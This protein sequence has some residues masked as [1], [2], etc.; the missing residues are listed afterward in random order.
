MDAAVAVSR[1]HHSGLQ[2]PSQLSAEASVAACGSHHSGLQKNT[3]TVLYWSVGYQN[4]VKKGAWSSF[5]K[6]FLE[7]IQNEILV[8]KFF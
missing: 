5:L 6:K 4:R 7:N 8:L 2:K 3:T 1:S